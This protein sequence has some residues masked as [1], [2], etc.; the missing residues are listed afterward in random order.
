ML[1]VEIPF[2]F[3]CDLFLLSFGFLYRRDIIVDV[4][5]HSLTFAVLITTRRFGVYP[6]YE[7]VYISLQFHGLD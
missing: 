7:E 4:C 1:Y 2:A 6:H 3:K 5:Y